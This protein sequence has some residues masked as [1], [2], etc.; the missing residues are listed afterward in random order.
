MIRLET[1]DVNQGLAPIAPVS[2]EAAKLAESLLVCAK[3]A[4][5]DKDGIAVMY[6][7]PFCIAVAMANMLVDGDAV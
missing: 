7:V 4:A 6:R 1:Q 2:P 3:K 5:V